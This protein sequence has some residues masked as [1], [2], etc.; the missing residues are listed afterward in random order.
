[1]TVGQLAVECGVP[2]WRLTYALKVVGIP[3]VQRVGILR[4]WSAE[5]LPAIRAAVE[6]VAGKR[7]VTAHAG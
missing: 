6:R 5:Q 7:E 3:P 2:T 1:M 4:V